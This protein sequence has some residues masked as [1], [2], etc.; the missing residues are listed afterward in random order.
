M[1]KKE[2]EQDKKR[3]ETTKNSI[4]QAGK[5]SLEGVSV[6]SLYKV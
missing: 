6:L 4:N 5:F 1:R 2:E 3:N